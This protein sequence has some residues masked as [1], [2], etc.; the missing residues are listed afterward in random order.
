MF[1]ISSGVIPWPAVVLASLL[2][3]GPSEAQK[4]E[5]KVRLLFSSRTDDPS[6]KDDLFLRPNVEQAVFVFAQNDGDRP[7]TV[8]VEVRGGERL[9]ASAPITVP[10]D[11][12]PH[13]V[14]LKAPPP[15]AAPPTPP[16]PGIAPPR[17][18]E[19]IGSVVIWLLDERGKPLGVPVPVEVARPGRYVEPPLVRYFP[20]SPLHP[21]GRLVVRV[22]PR[23]PFAG[24][25][26]RV[27]LVI[28]PERIPG[29]LPEQKKQGIYASFLTGKKGEELVLTAEGLRFAAPRTYRGPVEIRVDGCERAFTYFVTFAPAGTP[30]TP[31]EIN[32][33]TLQLDAPAFALPDKPL[34]VK[35]EIDHAP[36][37]ARTVL[38]VRRRVL[39]ETEDGLVLEDRHAVAAEFRGDRREALAGAAGPEGG[40]LFK[41]TLADWDLPVD[42]GVVHGPTLLRL[43]MFD[44]TGRLV[45][46]RDGRTGEPAE[47][48]QVSQVITFD[49][50][51]PDGVRFLDPP[52][53]ALPGETIVLRAT[54]DDP[55]SDIEKVEFFFGRPGSEGALPPGAEPVPGALIDAG[56]RTWSAALTVSRDR[57]DPFDVSVRFVKKAGPVAAASVKV[58]VDDPAER[59]KASVK[60]RVL[61]GDRPQAGI[62]VQ[63]LNPRGEVKGTAKTNDKGEFE[64]KGLEPGYYR[65][66]SIK[67]AGNTRGQVIIELKPGENKVLTPKEEIKLYR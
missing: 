59:R 40:L 31:V 33:P 46:V 66:A 11:G 39:V 58:S 17:P 18:D 26:C 41:T 20:P 62:D 34:R 64:V 2:F 61:E 49:G 1:P 67:R 5:S 9:L 25:P 16:A 52:R 6:P 51:R 10:D 56:R 53:G 29:L 32:R 24:P 8:T 3:P 57:K 54:S 28:R 43:R 63:A 55:P 4:P 42:L 21:A 35:A 47:R 30:T 44:A 14:R 60:G 7:R 36:R 50:Q 12:N 45:E 22:R 27:E 48:Q 23:E 65:L 38:E 37:G 19:G 15:P 13:L